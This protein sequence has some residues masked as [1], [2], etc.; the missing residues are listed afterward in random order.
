MLWALVEIGGG[1]EE[2]RQMRLPSGL[3]FMVVKP[4]DQMMDDIVEEVENMQSPSL[5]TDSAAA[6]ARFR[7][8]GHQVFPQS[9]G[10]VGGRD[11]DVVDDPRSTFLIPREA[12][13]QC[14]VNLHERV[15]SN[16]A[17]LDVGTRALDKGRVEQ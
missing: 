15:S 2:S 4:S 8:E 16:E 11:S 1:G 10:P 3:Q 7:R 14:L 12:S 17:N 9:R 13:M 5:E 6:V